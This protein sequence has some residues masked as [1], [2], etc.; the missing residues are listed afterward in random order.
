M[1][2]TPKEEINC[3]TYVRMLLSMLAALVLLSG[4]I[5]SGF[6]YDR[7]IA[8]ND[9]S[10]TGTTSGRNKPVGERGIDETSAFWW[11]VATSA[12]Q[13]ED[14]GPGD[15]SGYQTDW[16]V[17]YQR[18]KLKHARGHGCWSYSQVERDLNALA[19]LGVTHYRFSLEWARIE[20]APGEYNEAALQHYVD[21][22]KALRS[23]GITPV[24]TIWHFTFP[25]WLYDADA[26]RHGWLHPM[27][28]ERWQAFLEYVVPRLTPHVQTFAPLNEPNAYALACL[29]NQ[30]PPGGRMSYRRY[31]KTLD[32]EVARF[33]D[34]AKVI[35]QHRSDARIIS[36]Q[37]IIDWQ[38][39]PLD[40]FDFWFRKGQEYN[41]YHLDQVAEHCDWIGFNFY[42][43]ETASPLALLMQ[44]HRDGDDV[45]DLGWKIA[46]NGFEGRITELYQRYRKPLV[47]TENGLADADDDQRARFLIEHI[48]ALQRAKAAGADVRGYFH[49]SLMDNYEW[50]HGYT[51]KFGLYEVDQKTKALVPRASARVFKMLRGLFMSDGQLERIPAGDE[52]DASIRSANPTHAATNAA[53]SARLP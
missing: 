24:L 36:V 40:L 44:Q 26:D 35:R 29:V 14:F 37:N 38:R 9:Q 6:R 34:A 41:F 53:R 30:F 47:I 2:D 22:A 33:I 17:H 21:L 49:W 51:M 15:V 4:C 20:P 31:L 46:P 25:S 12:Y 45:S 18:G 43:A 52:L 8:S 16:D 32:A 10:A 27:A 11:G 1:Q 48:T 39:A 19:A 13:V 42:F 3:C 50:A 23:R 7:T 5:D 28:A